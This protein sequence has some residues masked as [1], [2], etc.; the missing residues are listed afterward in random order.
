MADTALIATRAA[1]V[2]CIAA[3]EALDA[4][5]GMA[6]VL[7]I[8]PDEVLIVAGPQA[9]E[10]IVH[11]ATAELGETDPH[12]LVTDVSDAW[13]GVT[14]A[15]DGARDLFAHLSPLTLPVTEGF[16][17][18]DVG[19]LAAKVIVRRPGDRITIL[20][21]APQAAYLRE[22]ILALGAAERPEPEPWSAP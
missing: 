21:P 16:L 13:S 4:I 5:A 7:R 8:A 2:S 3:S 17:Q 12:A 18:G 19:R 15:G 1:L 9:G 11:A 10:E 22:R 6:G 20:A 14:L